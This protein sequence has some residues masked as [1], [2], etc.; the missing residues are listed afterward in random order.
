MNKTVH[1][2]DVLGVKGF[3][4]SPRSSANVPNEVVNEFHELEIEQKCTESTE[5]VNEGT[6]PKDP[7][8]TE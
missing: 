1:K 3:L 8:D 6:E 4:M 7:L 5:T 2:T